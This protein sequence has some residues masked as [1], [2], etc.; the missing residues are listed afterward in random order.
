MQI[1]YLYIVRIH[2]SSGVE[3]RHEPSFIDN[4]HEQI[5]SQSHSSYQMCN[6][7]LPLMNCDH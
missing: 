4:L 3:T 6:F 1:I 7:S 2:L 5:I